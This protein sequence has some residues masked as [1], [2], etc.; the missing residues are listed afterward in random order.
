[1]GDVNKPVTKYFQYPP[2]V[3]LAQITHGWRNLLS[4]YLRQCRGER[5][6]EYEF[7]RIKEWFEELSQKYIDRT[8]L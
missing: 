8:E 7:S 5:H 1:M 6:E 4:I 2:L 3:G